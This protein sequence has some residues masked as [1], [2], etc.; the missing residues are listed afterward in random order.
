MDHS[1][2][3]SLILFF[4]GIVGGLI[5]FIYD[6]GKK[7]TLIGFARSIL[8]GVGAALLVPLFLKMISS[9]LIAET[10]NDSNNYFV[11]MGFCLV[12]AISSRS[13]IGSI[14]KKLLNEIKERTDEIEHNIEIVQ[15]QVQPIVDK[16]SEPEESDEDGA[17]EEFQDDAKA[18]I[19]ELDYNLLE[20]FENSEYT[21]RSVRGLMKQINYPLNEYGKIRERLKALKK[22]NLVD[23]ANIASNSPKPRWFLTT[24]G[25]SFVKNDSIHLSSK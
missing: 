21:L 22:L 8:L 18:K 11:L 9:T 5:N 24:S 17:K 20:A 14:S 7:L 16:A 23:E 13:F 1:I 15:T 4:S 6:D 25:R 19:T 12:A 10:A 2:I 3:V